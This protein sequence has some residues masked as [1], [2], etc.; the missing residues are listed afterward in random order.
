MKKIIAMIVL[1]G[2]VFT[3]TACEENTTNVSDTIIDMND[4][5]SE[6]ESVL[7]DYKDAMEDVDSMGMD[8]L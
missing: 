4:N 2:M 7:D 8:I 5:V 6:T 3:L 1:A